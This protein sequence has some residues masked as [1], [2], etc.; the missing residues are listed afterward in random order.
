MQIR[1]LCIALSFFSLILFSSFF[2]TG[3]FAKEPTAP[4]PS[5]GSAQ[6]RTIIKY[7]LP[8][9]GMLPDS[10]LYKIKVLRDKFISFLISDP[11]K[12]ADF[13]LLQAD[14]GILAAAMLI[15]KK[16]VSLAEETA[17]KA[18]HNM[19][20]LP[21]Q[22]RRQQAKP[23]NEVFN[24][25]KN[26]SKKHQEILSSILPRIEKR[27]EKSF[28]TVLYFSQKNLETIEKYEKKNPRRWNEW[29]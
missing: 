22:L 21:E 6:T 12:K 28:K 23:D 19:T 18:E 15:D 11:K 24:R 3:V 26:A 25:L 5:T 29:N 20:L 1:P 9:P 14:K 2:T 13:Y 10:P 7:D 16:N 4:M 8:F 17:L 27:D